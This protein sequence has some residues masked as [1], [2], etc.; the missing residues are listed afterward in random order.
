M[1]G[2]DLHVAA[3]SADPNLRERRLG[4]GRR[5]AVSQRP[6]L[7]DAKPAIAVGRTHAPARRRAIG[8]GVELR[9]G[10]GRC[11]GGAGRC[12]GGAGSLR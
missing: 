8:R 1:A 3:A 11:R 5:K 6:V 12:R 7:K 10:A 9:G 4:R 2:A